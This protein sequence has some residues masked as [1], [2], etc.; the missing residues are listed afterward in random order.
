MQPAGTTQPPKETSK[1]IPVPR[2][3]PGSEV[4]PLPNRE[5]ALRQV[6]KIYP[7]LEPLPSEP[8]ARQGPDGKP[9]TLSALQ[10]LAALNSPELQQAASD[11][12]AAEGN[13]N[14]A[15]AYP[16]PT[17]G[18]NFSPS[19]DNSVPSIQGP[20]ID[21]TIKV[22]NK[23]KL[24][25]AA[26]Q[27]QLE[28]AQ[29]NLRRARSDLA[30]RVRNAYYALLVAKETMR[31][32]HAMARFTDDIYRQH[33]ELLKSGQPATFEPSALSAQAYIARVA[34]SQAVQAY[35]YNWEQLVATLALRS[36]PLSEVEGR[37]DANIPYF[38]FDVVRAHV[39]QNHTDV[40]IARNGIEAAKYNLTLA[41]I[42]PV[43]DVTLNVAV[44]KDYAVPPKQWSPTVSVGVPVPFWDQNRGYI[45]SA[46]AALKRA[47]EEPHRVEDLW[48]ITLAGAYMSYKQN[49]DALE[50]FR[51]HILPDQVQY[52]RYTFDAYHLNPANVPFGNVVSAQQSLATSVTAY[53][54]VLG[55]LWTSVVT[56]ADA[57]Q[58]DDLFQLAKPLPVMPIPDLDRLLQPWPC[59]HTCPPA[60]S[61][62][63]GACS[64]CSPAPI[65]PTD[66]KV[67]LPSSPLP[68]QTEDRK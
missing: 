21:Q 20:F 30:T 7:P 37:I 51:K 40:L 12:T 35:V 43:P 25:A 15:K 47:S 45:R 10:H 65:I 18:W 19:S 66:H 4:P 2:E 54:T 68:A 3:V 52:Y 22:G 36:L 33:V 5:Q 49:L 64:S 53:L 57:L 55:Q 34:Y 16:N 9:Y 13:L 48:T 24:A 41:R 11:V 62:Q 29:L 58:T 56:V 50:I 8:V 6:D 28:N 32:T 17:M 59:C 67:N 38:D 26:A 14:T 39:L 46:E 31:I 61:A 63:P 60:V 44:A 27:K 1:T 42:T 23:L